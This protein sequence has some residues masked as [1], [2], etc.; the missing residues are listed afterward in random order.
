[1][2]Y[3]KSTRYAL[4]ATL[5]MALVDR[6]VTVGEVAERYGIPEAVL[7]KVLQG[8]VRAG[9]ARGVRGVGGGYVLARAAGEITTFDVIAVF[10]PPRRVGH[11]LLS[12]T[13]RPGQDTGA[14]HDSVACQHSI[15]CRLRAL[16]D[17]VDEVVR[18]TFSSVTLET[19]V[20]G[21]PSRRPL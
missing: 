20:R 21:V 4:Y 10:D 9:I 17:E 2:R 1:M 16:F 8:L 15:D 3:T 7:A 6:P 11:C 19:L 18:C 14:D 12:E 5:E 13:E